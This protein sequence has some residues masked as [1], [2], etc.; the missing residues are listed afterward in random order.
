VFYISNDKIDDP[1]KMADHLFLFNFL[2]LTFISNGFS[3]KE[4]K[5]IYVDAS[6]KN[7]P[8]IGIIFD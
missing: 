6:L 8:P 1:K 4:S 5:K 2:K 3:K 7:L